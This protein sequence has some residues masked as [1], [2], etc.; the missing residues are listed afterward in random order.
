MNKLGEK[1]LA[2]ALE[3][4]EQAQEQLAQAR[5]QM[6]AQLENLDSQATEVAKAVVELK[7]ILGLEEEED[8][9]DE[10]EA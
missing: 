6:E 8:E 2:Q 5:L 4:A 3:G 7:Q 9:V 1:Y 10:Q